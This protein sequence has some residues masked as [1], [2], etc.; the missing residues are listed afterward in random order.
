LIKLQLG[1]LAL[2]L[3][4]ADIITSQQKQN[5]IG[6]LPVAIEHVLAVEQLPA[7]HRDPFDRLLIAQAMVEGATLLSGDPAFA[8]YS[9]AV[10]W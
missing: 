2:T 8:A 5:R 7:H 10:A 9:V 1:K 6:I 4:L 3:P